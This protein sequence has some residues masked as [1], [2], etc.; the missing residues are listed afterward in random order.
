MSRSTTGR[1]AVFAALIAISVVAANAAAPSSVAGP[2]LSVDDATQPDAQPA[3]WQGVVERV[4]GDRFEL[5]VDT[6]W[7]PTMVFD[8]GRRTIDVTELTVFDPPVWNIDNLAVGEIVTV[9]LTD[10]GAV[11]AEAATVTVVDPD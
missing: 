4:E 6:V 1:A 2:A 5:T 9:A 10:P 3:L 8:I 7:A 11:P